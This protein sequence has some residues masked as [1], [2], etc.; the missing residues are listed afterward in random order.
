MPG[1]ARFALTMIF[2]AQVM[3]AAPTVSKTP[4]KPFVLFMGADIAVEKDQTMHPVEDVTSTSFVIK[5]RGR[6]VTVSLEGRANLH[7]SEALKIARTS[8]DVEGLVA[9]RAYATNNDPFE[10]LVQAYSLRAGEEAVADLARGRAVV[11]SSAAV[12]A[13]NA[14]ANADTPESLAA[15]NAGAAAAQANQQGAETA[16]LQALNTPIN[17]VFDTGAQVNK[18]GLAEG[19]FDA[20]RLSFDVISDK[21]LAQPYYAFIAQIRDRDSKPGQVRKWAF[22]KSLGTISAS[23]IRKVNVY[24]SGLPPGYILESYEVHLYNGA[25]ELATNLSRKRVLI[26]AEEAMD[27]RV[28]EYIGA[29]KGRTLPA[30]PV[31][32]TLPI[33][34]RTALTPAQL[35]GICYVRVA[36]DGRVI[37]VS[38]DGDGKQPLKDPALDLVLKTLRFKPAL[39]A[40][41]PIE[42]T[43]PLSLAEFAAL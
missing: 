18:M 15:A 37:V 43:I 32:A 23:V 2:A 4:S 13:G 8:V 7:I 41:K 39:E 35:S 10:K 31:F 5:P 20:I 42:S 36:K 28:V 26:T 17:S 11:A 40:G 25:E 24:R 34:T 33:E 12:G 22:V 6:P 14:F 38:R 9:E 3:N 1:L 16:A 19:N 29:N 21:D 30:S 27:F